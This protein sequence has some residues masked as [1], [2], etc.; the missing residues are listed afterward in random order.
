MLDPQTAFSG[1]LYGNSALAS[2]GLFGIGEL[3]LPASDNLRK[4]IIP[5]HHGVYDLDGTTATRAPP[6]S[7]GLTPGASV[8][9]FSSLEDPVLASHEAALRTNL[10]IAGRE[11]STSVRNSEGPHEE[12]SSMLFVD[13]LPN[14]CSRREVARILVLLLYHFLLYLF[15]PFIGFREIRVIHKESRRPGDKARVLCFVEF[16]DPKCARTAL[17]ALQGYK[18]DNS[19]PD[20]HPLKIQFA[21]FPLRPSGRE[22]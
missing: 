11:R 10:G 21:R 7:G 20:A 15:R 18:I 19:K 4:D 22:Q 3:H 17:E 8:R 5:E 14:D 9:R 1:L 13:G 6:I 12:Q 16:A 2:G